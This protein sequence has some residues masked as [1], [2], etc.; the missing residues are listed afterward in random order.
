MRGSY[1]TLVQ[2]QQAYYRQTRFAD[3]WA[4]VKRAPEAL[5]QRIQAIAGVAAVDTRVTLYATLDLPGLDA[6][7]QAR[8]V[9]LPAHARP[10]LND[11]VLHAGRYLAPGAANEV[12]INSKFAAARGLQ[13]GDRVRAIIF[14]RLQDLHIVG[15]ADSPEHTYVVPPGSLYPDDK[16][17]GV[18]WMS[19]QMLGPAYDMDAAFNEAVVA[20]DPG[21]NPQ[22]V[23]A[24]L[25]TL[26]APYGG[27]GA[28]RR[29]DQASHAILQSEL[30]Q[31]KVMGTAMPAVFLAVAAYLLNLVLSR[32]IAT[33]RPEIAV[34][35]AFGY[36]D[37][38]LALHYLL[39]AL[40]AVLAGAVIGTLL[41]L[42]LGHAYLALYGSYF[43]F[44]AL[45]FALSPYLLAGAM[46]VSV[47]A[48]AAG[49]LLAVRRAVLLPPAE[50]MRAEPP[51]SFQAG[52]LE[53]AG[54]ARG[55][56][57]AAHMVLRNLQRKPLQAL[58]SAVGVACS[59]AILMVGLVMFDGVASLMDLQFRV[60][61]R[62]DL[63]VSFNAPKAGLA[64][65]EIQQLPG[66]LR[67]EPFRLAPARLQFG[68]RAKDVLLQ[69]LTAD[70]VLRRIVGADGRVQPLPAAGLVL[71]SQ[72]A[73][74]LGVV[75]GDRLDIDMREGERRAGTLT[76]AGVVDG[77]LG[78]SA[79]LNLDALQ[80]LVGGAPMVSG[81]YL[82]VAADAV[83]A[84]E[85]HLKYLPAVAGVASPSAMLASF[86]QQMDDSLLIG[87]GFLLGFAGVIAMAVV[88]NGA[89]IALSER[90][91]ELAS[92]RVMGFRRREVSALLLGEQ[93]LITLL[94]IPLGWALGYGLSALVTRSLQT[95]A[96]SIPFVVQAQSYMLSAWIVIVAATASAMLVQRRIHHLD[97]I[98]VLKTR[99]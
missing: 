36:R 76:V 28:Y 14:G 94:A 78:A 26:L 83:P 40:A 13:P 67:V 37:R 31:N 18:L 51:A 97:L 57:P 75:V 21:A 1:D 99:E 70:G 32:L 33:Q 5:R 60:V 66:V 95:D 80:Q 65:R 85:R 61:Q 44:P 53:R 3:L 7:A 69:G 20:L 16:R 74:D 17:Y 24:Q 49:A 84:L 52:W 64:V 15:I 6:P 10:L 12:L 59:V 98:A 82:S 87:V 11:I 41:G 23:Q 73:R 45:A 72:L 22:A 58:M 35:K 54:L 50:A 86:Q 42:P 77:F 9:S 34:L 79:S 88:Y 89:R 47:L 2:A 71:S 62:E 56:P 55:L 29:Q 92:L 48:A 46:A 4:P 63:S 8:L 43:N 39:F 25:D 91:H 96:Y 68:H 90:G 30:D 19:R 81:A 93:A 38:E 27:L